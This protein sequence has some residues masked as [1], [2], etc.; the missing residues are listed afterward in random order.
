MKNPKYT[1]AWSPPPIA[2]RLE[3]VAAGVLRSDLYYRLAVFPINVL[4]AL[5][6]RGDDVR[7]AGQTVSRSIERRGRHQQVFFQNLVCA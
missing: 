4:P 6:E 3:A 2:I 7:L 1:C 5:R